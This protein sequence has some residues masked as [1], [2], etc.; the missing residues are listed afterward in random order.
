MP[1][2]LVGR[3]RRG[4]EL[5]EDTTRERMLALLARHL[6]D[7]PDDV[8]WDTVVLTDLGLDSMSAIELVLE[9]ED[10]LGVQFPEEL[11]VR[12]TF[13]TFAA[14]EAAVGTM[15]GPPAPTV[16]TFE[17][18]VRPLV[19]APDLAAVESVPLSRLPAGDFAVLAWLDGVQSHYP[20]P[21]AADL[22][23]RWDRLS[24]RDVYAL[25]VPAGSAAS[26]S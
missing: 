6:R 16:T 21:V 17:E 10:E 4:A 13:S 19:A 7:V 18:F 20:A 25:L 22:V 24:L 12:E 9:L 15:T 11:L 1:N 3:A 2:G 23:A 5:S 26:A 8:D 14:L